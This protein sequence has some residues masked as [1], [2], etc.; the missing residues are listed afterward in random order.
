MTTAKDE[1]RDV[2]RELDTAL[3]EL[4]ATVVDLRALVRELREQ[5]QEEMRRE[6]DQ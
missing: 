4:K 1:H 5:R 3:A 6:D 2:R